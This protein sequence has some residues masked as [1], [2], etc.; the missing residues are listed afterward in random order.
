MTLNKTTFTHKL[1]MTPPQDRETLKSNCVVCVIAKTLL[2]GTNT[3][4]TFQVAL[5]ILEK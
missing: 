2:H 1:G 5:C 3:D 4:Y